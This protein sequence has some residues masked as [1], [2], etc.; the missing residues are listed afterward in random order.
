MSTININS[1]EEAQGALPAKTEKRP[2]KLFQN[3]GDS[4][5]NG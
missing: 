5:N 3:L 2:L 4:F 1:S